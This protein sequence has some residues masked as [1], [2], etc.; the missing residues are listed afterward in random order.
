MTPNEVNI[1]N[2]GELLNDVYDYPTRDMRKKRFKAGDL[3][4]LSKYKHAFEKGYTPN[5]TTEIFKVKKIQ[6]TNPITY[7]LD[8]LRGE[9]IEG[10]IYA[11][12]M[13]LAKYPNVYLSKILKKKGNKVYV[14]WLGFSDE[15]NEWIDV[16][17]LI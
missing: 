13:Q 5:W 9:P 16:R 3:V 11:E 1:Y 10:G 7:L 6:H 8:D 4:R 12:E 15:F 17:N 14:K 2:E